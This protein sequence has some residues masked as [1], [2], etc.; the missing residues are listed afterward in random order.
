MIDFGPSNFVLRP[1]HY[2]LRHGYYRDNVN[3]RRWRF[4]ASND[5]ELWDTLSIH[6]PDDALGGTYGSKTWPVETEKWYRMFRIIVFGKFF[7]QIC[8]VE[9]YGNLLPR[10]LEAAT[11]QHHLSGSKSQDSLNS[12]DEEEE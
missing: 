5:G 3:L 8:G 7:V 10:T 2:T 6:D 1:K 9:L 11:V 12:S 4:E